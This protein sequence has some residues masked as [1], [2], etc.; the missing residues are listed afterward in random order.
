MRSAHL[1]FS[2]WIALLS[3]PA[4]AAVRYVN[5]NNPS[6]VAP[7][8]SWATA[9]T[10]I[11]D[12]IDTGAP[13]DQVLVTNGVYNVGARVVFGALSNRVVVDKPMTVRSVNGPLVTA[14]QGWLTNNDSAVRC[15]YLTNGA[16]LT[17]FTLANGSTRSDG[18]W[19]REVSGG[20]VW[21]ESAQAFITNC[22]FYGN[23]A[24]NVGGGAYGG[25]LVDCLFTN[26]SAGY[27]GG[28]VYNSTLIGC[29]LTG[30]TGIW[31]G[32]ACGSTLINCTLTGNSTH[33]DSDHTS[34]GG[35]AS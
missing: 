7:Y 25:T 6:P 27:S 30:N 13:G 34:N 29:A 33:D 5:L 31:G 32:G 9:A 18:D 15:V 16:A 11:Q 20:G 19:D 12:A 8:A 22:I 21:C 17:G 3:L 2:L 10:N 35:G 28:A 1:Y 4:P 14:I 23:T 24:P 26:N